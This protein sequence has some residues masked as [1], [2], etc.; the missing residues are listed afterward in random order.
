MRINNT[1]ILQPHLGGEELAH[2]VV[3]AL[4]AAEVGAVDGEVVDDLVAVVPELV[5][6]DPVRDL[7][8]HQQRQHVQGLQQ[9]E[10][11]LVTRVLV[12]AT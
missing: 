8:R 2:G 12:S 4:A 11:A 6:E 9:R 1:C 10:G 3:Y 7:Y 5:V